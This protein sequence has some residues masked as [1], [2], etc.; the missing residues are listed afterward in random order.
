MSLRIYSVRD[1]RDSEGFARPF[2][3]TNGVEASLM[4]HD[5]QAYAALAQDP[6]LVRPELFVGGTS[7]QAFRAGRPALPALTWALSFGQP[8]AVPYILLLLSIVG[9]VLMVVAGGSFLNAWGADPWAARWLLLLPATMG[10]IFFIGLTDAWATAAL[11]AAFVARRRGHVALAVTLL[12]VAVLFRE[13]SLFAVPLFLVA[14]RRP[15]WLLP[16]VVYGLWV[17]F[18]TIRVGVF[19]YVAAP[20]DPTGTRYGLP[21]AGILE[22]LPDW[23]LSMWLAVLST[24]AISA[25]AWRRMSTEVRWFTGIWWAAA[26]C[27]GS[28]VWRDAF[29]APRVML[30][31]TVLAILAI[32]VRGR[33]VGGTRD[34][35]ASMSEPGISD[36]VVAVGET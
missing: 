9:V 12:I 24:I 31:V 14:D 8:G 28:S 21:F 23:G 5:G 33:S 27:M 2:T 17:A 7:A 6:S 30:P 36:F 25:V 26:C 1:A 20:G 34:P 19:T 16:G 32:Q 3:V 29:D 10:V 22:R 35:K 15:V 4:L 13:T 11:L 18:V